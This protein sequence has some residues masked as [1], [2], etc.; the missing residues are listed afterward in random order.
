MTVRMMFTVTPHPAKIKQET[1]RS[2]EI[3]FLSY[4]RILLFDLGGEGDL[5]GET[6]VF[7]GLG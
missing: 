6:G 5:T 3:T 1:K 2:G 7:R 4:S